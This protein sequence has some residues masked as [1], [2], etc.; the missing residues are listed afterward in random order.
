MNP[1]GEMRWE[2]DGDLGRKSFTIQNSQG[3]EILLGFF[4]N[5]GKNGSFIHSELNLTSPAIP[6]QPLAPLDPYKSIQAK[7]SKEEPGL[8]NIDNHKD[9]FSS[10]ELSVYTVMEVLE[11]S[12]ENHDDT[13]RTLWTS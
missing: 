10:E 3:G 12:V 5:R 2:Y 11:V 9:R 6:D 13:R 4:R 8:A 1:Q 7:R